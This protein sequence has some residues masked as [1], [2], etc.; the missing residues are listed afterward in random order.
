[1][2]LIFHFLIFSNIIFVISGISIN[3]NI[4]HTY[5]KGF[6]K[7]QLIDFNVSL[8]WWTDINS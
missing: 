5:G 6:E 1:M 4:A 7:K 2:E 3:I 8:F